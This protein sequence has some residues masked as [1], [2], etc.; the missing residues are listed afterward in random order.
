M[1][2]VSG[3][4]QKTTEPAMYLMATIT[5]IRN[6]AKGCLHGQAEIFIRVIIMKMR[7]M[8]MV[9][10]SGLMEVCTKENGLEGSSM[11][12]EE[13]CF[14]MVLLRKDILKI[15]YTNMQL[16]AVTQVVIQLHQ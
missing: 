1:V 6:M 14:L 4:V 8:E 15:M 5:R 11:V 12:L 3:K 9:K 2:A 13:W 10:C 16:V 7:G